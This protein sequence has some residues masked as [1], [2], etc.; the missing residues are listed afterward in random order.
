MRFVIKFFLYLSL[1]I[2]FFFFDDIGFPRVVMIFFSLLSTFS[3]GIV[4]SFVF[5]V[6]FRSVFLRFSR[7]NCFPC[8]VSELACDSFVFFF[9][10]IRLLVTANFSISVKVYQKCALTTV[11]VLICDLKALEWKQGAG[12]RVP[13]RET[14]DSQAGQQTGRQAGRCG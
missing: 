13:E 14:A 3:S 4:F 1:F 10:V 11:D 9:H 7:R 2:I 6:H 12:R 5:R 8:C